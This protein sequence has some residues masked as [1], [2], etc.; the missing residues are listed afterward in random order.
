MGQLFPSHL[1]SRHADPTIADAICDRVVHNSHVLKLSGQSI[2]R[3]ALQPEAQ[4][5]A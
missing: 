3:K 5:S 4:P 1:R 2:R